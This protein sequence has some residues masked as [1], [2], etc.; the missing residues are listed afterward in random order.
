LKEPDASLLRAAGA[1][2]FAS[3][4]TVLRRYGSEIE[5]VRSALIVMLDSVVGIQGPNSRV[6]R[7]ATVVALLAVLIAWS[8][9]PPDATGA[10]LHEC[11]VPSELSGVFSGFRANVNCH[12]AVRVL[13]N[14]KCADSGCERWVSRGHAGRYR[15]RVEPNDQEGADFSCVNRSD[16]RKRIVVFRSGS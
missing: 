4:P 9:A 5:V 2:R 8:G 16:D 12:E 7:A 6:A 3:S 1:S 11:T 14:R 10:D 15:C 13:R